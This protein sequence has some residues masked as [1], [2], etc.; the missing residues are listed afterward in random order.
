[1]S[2]MLS[3]RSF[4]ETQ[5]GRMTEE[6]HQRFISGPHIHLHLS[7]CTQPHIAGIHSAHTHV[8]GYARTCTLETAEEYMKNEERAKEEKCQRESL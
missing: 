8:C 7:I 4:L 5:R 6:I 3:E 2:G 1:M